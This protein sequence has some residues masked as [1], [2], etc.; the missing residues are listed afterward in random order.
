MKRALCA[1]SK[2]TLLNAAML[3]LLLASPALASNNADIYGR[4]LVGLLA[5]AVAGITTLAIL[6]ALSFKVFRSGEAVRIWLVLS[7]IP[8]SFTALLLSETYDQNDMGAAVLT[9]AL[10]VF[11]WCSPMIQYRLLKSKDAEAV[12]GYRKAADKGETM[13]MF[14]LGV[15]YY[16]GRGV[17]RDTVE[18]MRWWRKAADNGDATA[19]A[20]LH[21]LGDN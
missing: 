21:R 16:N 6:I 7:A 10:I 19:K 12:R 11:A 15:F 17:Q 3:V 5:L 1:M 18:A 2:A 9:F 13:A 20:T 14:N 8:Y 4:G